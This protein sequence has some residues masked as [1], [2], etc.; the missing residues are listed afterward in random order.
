LGF[1][2]GLVSKAA[3]WATPAGVARIDGN[4]R[5]TG[6]PRLGGH[7]PAKLIERPPV[8]TAGLRSCS[9]NPFA[10]LREVFNRNRAAGAFSVSNDLPRDA[11]VC[12]FSKSG[13]LTRQFLEL[14]FGGFA[15][16]TLKTGATPRE[17]PT[18]KSRGLLARRVT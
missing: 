7:K 13:L 6:E 9:R 3:L 18:A 16:A 5:D 8:Q 10:D 12:V 11:V 1:A 2:I 17:L 4:D 15:A 14:A